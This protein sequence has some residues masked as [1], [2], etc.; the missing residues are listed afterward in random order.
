MVS[1]VK[2]CLELDRDRRPR[3]AS[4]VAAEVTAYLLHVLRRP[5]REMARFFELS[6]DL[7]CLAGLDEFFKQI[8][9]NFTRVLGYSTEELLAKP[10][11]DL[12][13]PDDCEQTRLQVVKLSRDSPSSVSRTAIEIG[14]ATTSGLNGRPS[15]FPRK[16][17][18]SPRL[19]TSPS[20]NSWNKG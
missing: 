7:F 15:P 14:P 16:E 13:H 2:R 3:N 9:Q 18:F 6:L 20:G 11:I 8:N 4:E 5:E 12:V 10:F 19:V 1:L 17:S